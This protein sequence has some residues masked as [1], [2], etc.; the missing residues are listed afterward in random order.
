MVEG[1]ISV[2]IPTYNGG[3]KVLRALESLRNQTD[4]NFEVIVVN[5]GST[6]NTRDVLE[7]VKGKYPFSIKLIHQSNQGR[8]AVRNRGAREAAGTILVF[9]DDDMRHRPD[10]IALHSRH[11]AMFPG[12]IVVGD[13]LEDFDAVTKD[14]QV[15]KGI[16]AR[17]WSA[18]LQ[19]KKD[20]MT[21]DNLFLTAANFSLPK[22]L[23][24]KLEGFDERLTD[25]ED[26]DLG[27]RAIQAGIPVY[28]N[29][30]II[31]WHD[32]FITCRSYI[33]RLRQYQEAQKRI[34]LLKPDLYEGYNR[35]K[36]TA[37]KG[38]KRIVFWLFGHKFWVKAIDN[39]KWIKFLPKAIR[40]R[41]YTLVIDSLYSHFQQTEIE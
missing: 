1:L 3:H 24:F 10:G 27:L 9:M 16:L 39:E 36:V 30:N 28:F 8:S 15:Y 22:N 21:R 14:I 19:N 25:A 20:P 38:I 13:Q 33:K 6:D 32:D 23:F 29:G 11:H 17:K 26:F 2:I 40:Y 18:P 12:S 41:I 31:G 34:R 37:A 4:L 7:Q 35:H 5:D